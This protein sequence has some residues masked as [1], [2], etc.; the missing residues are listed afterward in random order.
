[1]RLFVLGCDALLALAIVFVLFAS[2]PDAIAASFLSQPIVQQVAWILVIA[3]TLG[4]LGSALWLNEQLLQQRNAT[5]ILQS[6]L[7]VEEAQKDVDLAMNQLGRTVSDAAMRELQQRLAKAEKEL[8]EHMRLS[9]AG[10]FQALVAEIRT[11]QTALKDKL[12]EAVTKRRSI[13]QLFTEYEATQRDIE[14][15]LGGIERD[16]KGDALEARIG[17]LSQFTK[18]T[19]SRFAELEQ[20]KQVLQQ[21][22]EEYAAL[23]GRLQPLKDERTGIKA[24]VQQLD[25]LCAQLIANIEAMERQGDTRLAERVKRIGENRRELSERVASLAEELSKLDSSHKDIDSLFVRLSN[26]LQARSS[27]GTKPEL[28]S[29]KAS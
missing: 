12:G 13:D 17:N 24:R 2:G 21:L 9:E 27:S 8:G 19:E 6:R 29:A 20:S 26:E 22:G 3:A 1:M 11:R 15:I 18:V 5:Q 14:R 28:P 10:E 23:E 25:G 4:V 16:Q 7:R